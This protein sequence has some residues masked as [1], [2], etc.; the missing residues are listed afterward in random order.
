MLEVG[1][2]HER[3]GEQLLLS[4]IGQDGY[5]VF[6][7]NHSS[8]DLFILLRANSCVRIGDTNSQLSSPLNE[9]FPV[10]G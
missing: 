10:L 6:Q 7:Q 3:H 8:N 1:R 4:E 9:S 5:S 2:H